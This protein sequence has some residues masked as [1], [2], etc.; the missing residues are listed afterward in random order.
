MELIGGASKNK[1]IEV[2]QRI[3]PLKAPGAVRMKANRCEQQAQ[4]SCDAQG[5]STA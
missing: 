2:T 4:E 1:M 5:N 3:S